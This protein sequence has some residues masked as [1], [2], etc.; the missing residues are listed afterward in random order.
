M[1]R[2]DRY[3][4]RDI[5]GAHYLLPVGQMIA[6]FHNSVRINETGILIWNLLENDMT[7]TD[8]LECIRTQLN[9]TDDEFTSLQADFE[10]FLDALIKMG[11]AE[12]DVSAETDI[13]KTYNIAGITLHISAPAECFP[14]EL[15][16][17]SSDSF[18]ENVQHIQVYTHA[19]FAKSNGK[20]IIR[21]QDLCIM[22]N[23]LFFVI[24]FPN[25]KDINEVHL[26]KD[27]TNADFY[28][29]PIF[30]DTLRE[31]FFHAL[32]LTFLYLSEKHG[33]Y[34]IHSAS[35]L[36]KNKAWLFSGCSGTGKSTHTNLWNAQYGTP[37]I[38]G[39]LNLIAFENNTAV[40]YG[41]PWCGTSGIYSQ[42]TYR[43]GGITLLKQSDKDM[44]IQLSAQDKQL[45]VMKRF[46]SPIWNEEM[47]DDILA[48]TGQLA[49]QIPICRLACTKDVHAAAVMK[50]EIDKY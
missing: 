44:L 46:I 38:N 41:I 35:I 3:I 10:N 15:N 36:Y 17:F 33:M 25:F 40:V 14:H 49:A 19:P 50:E 2:N 1:K 12:D 7:R 16:I 34:A 27:G 20:L 18:T 8:L 22:E 45:L 37:V 24:L 28:C 29:T 11:I 31:H 9:A 30:F 4:L 42:N 23:D 48:F 32:R 6:D 26:S 5:A 47:L 43:L 39:D 13:C 21:N